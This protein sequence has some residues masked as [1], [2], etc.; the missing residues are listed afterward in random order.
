MTVKSGC[1]K[2]GVRSALR[3]PLASG[4]IPRSTA[5]IRPPTPQ[6]LVMTR[7]VHRLPSSRPSSG[8]FAVDLELSWVDGVA[9]GDDAAFEAIFRRYNRE[10]F[11]F[12][13][14]MS[15]NPDDAEDAVQGVFVAIWQN[16]VGWRLTG[17][18]RAYLFSA[19]RKRVLEQL[20]TSRTRRRHHAEVL[21]F[22]TS[23]SSETLLEPDGQVQ[24]RDLARAVSAAI[25]ALPPRCREAF[26]LTR[27]C[28]M[29]YQ[30]AA[31]TMGI[32]PN[33]VMVQIGRALIAL[34]KAL[35][36][37]LLALLALR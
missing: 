15:G 24:H 11:R 18:L 29:T 25:A 5:I 9:A 12:A 23:Y 27:H 1:D 17:S 13:R 4:M 8:P 32:S 7:P 21:H 16:R 34:R 31:T 33:T 3:R 2:P 14:S 36:P 19:V 20:R 22:T 6:Q 35:G 30:E 28:G 37:F 10:L 26:V